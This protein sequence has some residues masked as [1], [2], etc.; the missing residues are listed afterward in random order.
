MIALPYISTPSI[1]IELPLVGH[2]TITPF[3]ALVVIGVLVGLRCCRRMVAL[4]GLDPAHQL[5]LGAQAPAPLGQVRARLRPAEVHLGDDRQHG[6]LVQDRMQPRPADDDVDLAGRRGTRHADVLAVELEQA[7]E[8]DEVRLHEA[9]RAQVGQLPVREAQPAQVGDLG[10]DLVQVGREVD[11]RRAALEAVLDLRAGEMVQHD[12][13]H[14]ELVQ[15]G[16]QQRVDQHG[17][18]LPGPPRRPP[19]AALRDPRYWI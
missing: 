14:G 5:D 12:L 15:V 19:A 9:Q 6:D 8:I 18:I 17:G 2:H 11:A 16:V 4:R 7:E 1:T 13:H 10:R 3:G